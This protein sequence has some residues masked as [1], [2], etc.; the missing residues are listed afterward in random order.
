VPS[1]S[2]YQRALGRSFD[3][4]SPLLRAYFGAIPPDTEG[5]GEGIF[6]EIGLR[7]GAL[8]PL[9]RLLGMRRIAFAEYGEDIAFRIRNTPSPAGELHATRTFFF[10]AGAQVMTDS[11][12]V[13]DGRLIDRIGAAGEVEVELALRVVDGRLEMRSRRLALRLRRLRLALPRIVTVTLR[14]QASR[15]VDGAQDVDL[16][17][18]APLVGLVYGYRGTFTY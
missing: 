11:M 1:P 17:I 10:P 5:V 18:T 16:R 13:A 14:E 15:E 8:R 9:F 6:R 3:H 4:L 12:R 7:V 2:V